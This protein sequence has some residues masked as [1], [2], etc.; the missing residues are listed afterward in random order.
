MC[1][2]HV[3]VPL[4]RRPDPATQRDL[5][6]AHA[7]RGL[8]DWV[9]CSSCGLIGVGSDPASTRWETPGTVGYQDRER[10]LKKAADWNAKVD[11]G[12]KVE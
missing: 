5:A 3:P 1:T 10:R 11:A 4:Y 7:L 2:R 9:T 8:A 12:P 6:I